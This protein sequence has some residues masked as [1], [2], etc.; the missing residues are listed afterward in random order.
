MS[1]GGDS[2]DRRRCW[3]G[4]GI[5]LNVAFQRRRRRRRRDALMLMF[6]MRM[7]AFECLFIRVLICSDGH[8]NKFVN[9]I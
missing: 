3:W 9:E 5:T 6:G 4:D 2:S 1:D 7:F 8:S